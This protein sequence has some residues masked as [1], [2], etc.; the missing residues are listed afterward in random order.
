M[1]HGRQKDECDIAPTNWLNEK[2]NVTL[3]TTT[4]NYHQLHSKVL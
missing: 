4:A 3:L 2:F 1:L